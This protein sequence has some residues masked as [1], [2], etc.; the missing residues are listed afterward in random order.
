MK[1]ETCPHKDRIHQRD[2]CFTIRV[3]Y[4]SMSVNAVAWHGRIASLQQQLDE[5]VK[6]IDEMKAA[7][8][9]QAEMVIIH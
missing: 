4:L 7:R 9:R 5:S 8:R 1:I 3:W 6:E 2:Y